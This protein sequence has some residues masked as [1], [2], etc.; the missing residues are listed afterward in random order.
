MSEDAHEIRPEGPTQASLGQ[1]PGLRCVTET[2]RPGWDHRFGMGCHRP[3]R[4]RWIRGRIPGVLLRPNGPAQ[5]SPGQ[6]PGNREVNRASPER[7]VELW[8]GLVVA[9][10]QGSGLLAN[11]PRAL[12]W[13]GLWRPFGPA[14]LVVFQTHPRP[15]SA[16]VGLKIAQR[17]SA[18][19]EW[20]RGRLV[21]TGTKEILTS[22]QDCIHD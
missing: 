4:V 20:L 3:C 18:G 2:A 14:R 11:G 19:Y 22:L 21:P 7:A 13:A 15:A 12:P 5:A 6:R 17:L 10:F 16:G 9:P 8:R 1:R